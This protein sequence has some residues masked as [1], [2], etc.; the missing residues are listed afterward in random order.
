MCTMDGW[1]LLRY[2]RWVGGGPINMYVGWVGLH[3]NMYAEWVG[4]PSTCTMAGWEAHQYIH[5]VDGRAN[6]CI[7]GGWMGG[8]IHMHTLGEL[9][10]PSICT[11]RDWEAPLLCTPV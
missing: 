1:E 10:A 5:S 7:Y 8:P 4:A 9:D 2:V 11:L 3:F 6:Q